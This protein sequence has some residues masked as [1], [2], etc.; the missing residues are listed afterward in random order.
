MLQRAATALAEML[1]D[2]LGAAQ[3]GNDVFDDPAFMS[4]PAAGA[5]LGANP[6]TRNGKRQ[7]NGLAPPIGDAVALRAEPSDDELDGFG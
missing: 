6:I 4:R 7:K 1:A 3:A 5:D 2:R